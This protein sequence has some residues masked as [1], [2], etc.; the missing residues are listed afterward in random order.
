MLTSRTETPRRL[1]AMC[2]AL[3]ALLLLTACGP[4]G[5]PAPESPTAGVLPLGEPTPRPAGPAP[6][7][8]SEGAGLPGRLLFVRSGD[9][10]LWQGEHGSQ[11]TAGGDAYQPAWSPGG[12]RIAYIKRGES[13]SDLMLMPAAGG[14][15]LQL[16]QNGSSEPPTS[17]ERIYD[18]V[19][20]FYPAFSP[21]GAELAF[22]SQYGPPFGSPATD[23]HLALFSAPAGAGGNRTLLYADDAGHV[24]RLAYAP[25]GATIVFAF[26]PAGA[27]IPQLY[28]YDTVAAAAAPIPEA[29]EQSYDPVFSP[30]GQWL[31]FAAR[32]GSATD[33]FAMPAAG[34]AP[35]RLTTL[36]AARAPAF[37]PDGSLVAFL[38]VAP[39]ENSFDLWVAEVRADSAGIAL[40][41]PRRVTEGMGIDVDSGLAWSE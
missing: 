36:G 38:A 10:W 18:V 24:G 11:L 41:E 7:V 17:F 16:T 37:S 4:A 30:D 34:G 5:S 6:T 40:G 23:Y 9:L 3:A 27:G 15:A 28:R 29:P 35:V 12:E 14:E 8:V 31:V 1:A 19:W 20:A 33:L 25:D 2:F 26:G 39:G 22:V 13:Y 21:D 32:D